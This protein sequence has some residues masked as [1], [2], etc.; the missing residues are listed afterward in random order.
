ML[1]SLT[2]NTSTSCADEQLFKF[3]R[4]LEAK[5]VLSSS[6]ARTVAQIAVDETLGVVIFFPSYFLAYELMQSLLMLRG[7]SL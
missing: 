4:F 5:N 1:V 2:C 3:G 6:R 7:E